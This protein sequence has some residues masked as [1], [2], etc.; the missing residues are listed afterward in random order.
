MYKFEKFGFVCECYMI[1]GV[2]NFIVK[3][4]CGLLYF[5]FSGYIDVVL[6]GFFEKWKLFF[7]SFVVS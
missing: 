6:L 1:N 7:F 4:G 5:V 2:K 3:W